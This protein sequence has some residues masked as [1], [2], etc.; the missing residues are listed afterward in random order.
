MFEILSRYQ[1]ELAVDYALR[2]LRHNI[3][4]LRLKPGQILRENDLTKHLGLSRTPLRE[5]LIQLS[6]IYLVDIVPQSR[7][8]VSLID[9]D[10]IEEGIFL[11]AQVEPAVVEKACSL[12]TDNDIMQLEDILALQQRLLKSNRLE[13]LLIQD[14]AFHKKL[15][16]VCRMEKTFQVVE[17]LCGQYDIIRA[18]S[19]YHYTTAKAVEDHRN[20]FNAIQ[21]GDKKI[22]RNLMTEHI[23]RHSKEYL[24]IEKNF[25]HYF[26]RCKNPPGI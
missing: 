5:A 2:V 23:T 17:G 18:L 25:P 10:V 3:M 19:L 1:G 21:E 26:T 11:R 4:T 6:S 13:E 8:H 16:H 15:Y 12:I 24:M 20:I 22:A 7:T 14:N 9:P